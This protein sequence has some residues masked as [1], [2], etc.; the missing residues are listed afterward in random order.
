VHPSSAFRALAECPAGRPASRLFLR[1]VE[2]LAWTLGRERPGP[3]SDPALRTIVTRLGPVDG[4]AVR[5][6]RHQ[7]AAHRRRLRDEVLAG[8]RAGWL[9][10]SLATRF[11]EIA[12]PAPGVGDPAL[13]AMAF[14]HTGDDDRSAREDLA[15][16]L[17]RILAHPAALACLDD[18]EMSR[19]EIRSV[20]EFAREVGACPIDRLRHERD[21]RLARLARLVPPDERPRSPAEVGRRIGLLADDASLADDLARLV[22]KQSRVECGRLL[23]QPELDSPFAGAA[24]NHP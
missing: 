13:V 5:G 1:R 20:I 22:Q 4:P 17:A 21:D 15:R 6:L 10:A 12:G 2:L 14:V 9:P 11:A 16:R 19:D 3:E 24:G 8:A 18:V 23:A 7:F